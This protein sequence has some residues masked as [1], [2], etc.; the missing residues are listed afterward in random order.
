MQIPRGSQPGS[1]GR[2]NGSYKLGD[3]PCPEAGQPEQAARAIPKV[4][5]PVSAPCTPGPRP[6]PG[7]GVP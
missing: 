2:Q 1:P 5:D 4:S 6:Q 3:H 7:D